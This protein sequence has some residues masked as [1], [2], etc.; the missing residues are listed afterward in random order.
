MIIA[1]RFIVSSHGIEPTY[2]SLN[3]QMGKEN[4]VH[5]C[6]WILLSC[7]EKWNYDLSKKIDSLSVVTALTLTLARPNRDAAL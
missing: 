6:T 5:T 4:V 7:K 1:A 2:M 3:R